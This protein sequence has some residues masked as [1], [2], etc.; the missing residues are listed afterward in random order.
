VATAV[1]SVK[2]LIDQVLASYAG[3]TPSVNAVLAQVTQSPGKNVVG[4]ALA[5]A[6]SATLA[7]HGTIIPEYVAPPMTPVPITPGLGGQVPNGGRA[8]ATP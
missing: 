4:G 2:G 3:G 7:G 1:P 5:A 8:Y 6:P